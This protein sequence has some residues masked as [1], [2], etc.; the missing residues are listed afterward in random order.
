[1]VIIEE[2]LILYWKHCIQIELLWLAL[3]KHTFMFNY[4][5]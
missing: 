2:I 5:C 1:M 3:A 4:C